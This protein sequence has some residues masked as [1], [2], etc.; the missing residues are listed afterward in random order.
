MRLER[1]LNNPVRGAG[2][3]LYIS[4]RLVEAMGGHIWI[5]SKGIPGEGSI[6]TFTLKRA[7]QG[8]ELSM[9]RALHEHQEV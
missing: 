1:D 7:Y 3:G 5:E 6:F 9:V 2:L 8:Q 4:K